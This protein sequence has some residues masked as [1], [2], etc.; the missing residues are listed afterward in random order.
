MAQ[1]TSAYHAWVFPW[2]SQARKHTSRGFTLIELLVVISIIA[3]LV[4][5]LLPALASARGAVHT[6]RCSSNMRQIG[7][8][9]Q[10]YI[11]E[12][13]MTFPAAA[14]QTVASGGNEPRTEVNDWGTN[15]GDTF[16][17][18][19]YLWPY[20]GEVIDMWIDPAHAGGDFANYQTDPGFADDFAN[21]PASSLPFIFHNYAPAFYFGLRGADRW[22]NLDNLVDP[23]TTASMGDFHGYHKFARLD[24]DLENATGFVYMPG[25][26]EFYQQA[27]TTPEAQH[28]AGRHAGNV[29]N[30]IWID[31][32]ATT[33]KT[34]EVLADSYNV[35]APPYTAG[36]RKPLGQRHTFFNFEVFSD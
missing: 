6:V 33:L 35:S 34:T 18:A 15:F 5:I 19:Q 1:R 25:A 20:A 29:F 14:P 17:H 26:N 11:Q 8:A 31:G 30:A 2:R 32:H 21:D 9:Q 10:G 24:N 36:N 12:N 23:S 16:F 4:A 22:R 7:I 28:T 27:T 13:K 3:I